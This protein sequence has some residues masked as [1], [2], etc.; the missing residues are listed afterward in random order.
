MK[1]NRPIFLWGAV[2]AVLCACDIRNEATYLH[3]LHCGS[4]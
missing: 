2:S 1:G 3:A 4:W